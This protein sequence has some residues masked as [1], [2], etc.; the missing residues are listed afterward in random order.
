[1][2]ATKLRAAVLIVS[3]TASENPSSDRVGETLV[4]SL[5]GPASSTWKHPVTKIVPDQVL[6]IQRAVCEW[7]DGPDSFNLIITSGGTG[8]AVKDNT[9]EVGWLKR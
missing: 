3:D 9:P 1:M 7:A 6:D 4:T 8:F 5:T 2:A